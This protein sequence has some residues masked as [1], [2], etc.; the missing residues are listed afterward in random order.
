MMKKREKNGTGSFPGFSPLYTWCL[1]Q[2]VQSCPK[3]GNRVLLGFWIIMA[4]LF[5]IQDSYKYNAG[6]WVKSISLQ[7]K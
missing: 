2:A 3:S 6:C 7:H 4:Y 5:L 1:R